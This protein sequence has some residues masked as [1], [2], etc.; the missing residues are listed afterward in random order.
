MSGKESFSGI[1][2]PDNLVETVLPAE[3]S[4]PQKIEEV[5]TQSGKASGKSKA[6]KASMEPTKPSVKVIK[7]KKLEVRTPEMMESEIAAAE[8]RLEEISEQMG[9]P[10]VARDPQQL[11]KLDK[12][13]R[14]V[15]SRLKVLYEEWETAAAQKTG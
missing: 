14:E 2:H 9:L 1:S 12:E 7:K 15:E 10:E 4:E 5:R 6:S 13:Y 11:I 3:R 8:K